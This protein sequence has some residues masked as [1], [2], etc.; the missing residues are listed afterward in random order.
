V[1]TLCSFG[2]VSGPTTV[3]QFPASVPLNARNF[4]TCYERSR[5]DC[6]VE[7]YSSF[8]TRRDAQPGQRRSGCDFIHGTSPKSPLRQHCESPSPPIPVCRRL[9]PRGQDGWNVTLMTH[10]SVA[11]TYKMRSFAYT[12]PTPP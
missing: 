12:S 9:R 11:S 1:T 4:L 3:T 5:E 8:A 6:P 2:S 10:L 7:S